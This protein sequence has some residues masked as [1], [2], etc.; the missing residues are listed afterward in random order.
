[1]RSNWGAVPITTAGLLV[2]GRGASQPRQ[3]PTG[4]PDGDGRASNARR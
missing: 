4:T 3:R 2:L 1:M